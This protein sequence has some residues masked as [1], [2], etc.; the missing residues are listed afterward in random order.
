MILH[1]IG[2]IGFFAMLWAVLQYE[3]TPGDALADDN[4]PTALESP[5]SQP[6]RADSVP[7]FVPIAAIRQGTGKG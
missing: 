7:A 4:G 3:G 6:H 2:A 5:R 1:T